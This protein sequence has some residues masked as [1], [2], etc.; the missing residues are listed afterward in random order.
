MNTTNEKTMDY[1]VFLLGIVSYWMFSA[2]WTD[3]LFYLFFDLQFVLNPIVVKIVESLLLLLV[4]YLLFRKPRMFNIRWVHVVGVVLLMVGATC[5]HLA[6]KSFLMETHYLSNAMGD[7]GVFSQLMQDVRQWTHLISS[8]IIILFLWWRCSARN[9]K[10]GSET[11]TCVARSYYGGMLFYLFFIYV[12]WL[13][14]NIVQNS[15]SFVCHP[16]LLEGISYPL[17]ILVAAF[18]VWMLVRK[19][20]MVVPLIV[21]LS[22]VAAHLFAQYYLWG[23]LD[24]QFTAKAVISSH[25]PLFSPV[26]N[27]CG[28]AFFLTAFILYRRE[29]KRENKAVETDV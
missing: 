3:V 18:A 22:V 14:T 21:I 8:V 24:H 27:L 29:V 25:R 6:V 13:I 2:I 5:V 1:R 16:I 15:R 26:T 28:W 7:N 11:D 19:H 9:V 23:I 17:L 12:L 20:L 4:F 10:P